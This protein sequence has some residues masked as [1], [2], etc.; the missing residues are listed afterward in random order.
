MEVL[1][2]WCGTNTFVIEVIDCDFTMGGAFERYLSKLMPNEPN[3][4]TLALEFRGIN[5]NNLMTWCV[6]VRALRWLYLDANGSQSEVWRTIAAAHAIA[7]QSRGQ[8]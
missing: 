6:Q 3:Q 5:W 7:L 4:I 1:Q 8:S 2:M